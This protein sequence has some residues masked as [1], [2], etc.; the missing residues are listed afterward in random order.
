LLRYDFGR[1]EK[2]TAG[3]FHSDKQRLRAF[4]ISRSFPP[5]TSVGAFATGIVNPA[6]AVLS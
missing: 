4:G 3:Y 5:R 6:N 1:T 2:I